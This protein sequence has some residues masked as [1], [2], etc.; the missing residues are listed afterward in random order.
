LLKK[1]YSDYPWYA[2]QSELRD[3][4]PEN[5]PTNGPA[6]IAIYTVGYEGKSVDAFF[7]NL[8]RHGM[9]ALLDVRANPVSRKYG[10]AA[11]SLREIGAKLG[12]AYW[13]LP[14]LGIEGAKRTSLT[15]FAAYQKLLDHY[16]TKML[17]RQTSSI[18]QLVKLIVDRP[19]ALL[20]MERDVRCCHRS[21]L[22][23]AAAEATGLPVVHL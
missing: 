14:A 22:A 6:P 10:F 17:P 2:T 21:R 1:V 20:C 15:S 11:K 13:H 9:R 16:Q 3:L 8:M 12:L 18:K 4:V 7:D 5:L 19:S 23:V